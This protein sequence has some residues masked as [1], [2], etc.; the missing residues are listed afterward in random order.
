MVHVDL[1]TPDSFR[2]QVG[3]G[4]VAVVA[5]I[6]GL[7]IVRRS[8][9]PAIVRLNIRV[10]CWIEVQ[11]CSR[12]Q[13]VSIDSVPVA[14]EANDE[15]QLLFHEIFILKIQCT[16]PVGKMAVKV[17]MIRLD[18]VVDLLLPD[19]LPE[20]G[21]ERDPVPVKED[22]RSVALKIPPGSTRRV[23]IFG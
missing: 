6:K 17:Q 15:G 18:I 22:P 12:A 3:V 2:I 16:D 7:V 14:A 5:R 8:K 19:V 23:V 9:R 10:W 1:P 20:F 13:R 4:G 11:A 21:A